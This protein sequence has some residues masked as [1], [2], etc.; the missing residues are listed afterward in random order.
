MVPQGNKNHMN[1][2]CYGSERACWPLAMS[3]NWID[4]RACTVTW[5]LSTSHTQSQNK[6][7]ASHPVLTNIINHI[8]Q[9]NWILER[10][11]CSV[12]MKNKTSI[13]AYRGKRKWNNGFIYK[14]HFT[15]T[16]QYYHCKIYTEFCCL[17]INEKPNSI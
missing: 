8:L 1:G 4:I 6:P 11:Y 15:A 7:S 16:K 2:L 14:N 12:E 10:L 5:K 13:Q 3:V 17:Y 9:F